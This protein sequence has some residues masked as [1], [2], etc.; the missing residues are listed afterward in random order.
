MVRALFAST[1]VAGTLMFIP[2][3]ISAQQQSQS[4]LTDPRMVVIPTRTQDE[5]SNDIDNAKATQQ[6]AEYRREQAEGRLKQVDETIDGRKKMMGEVDRRK[7]EAKKSKKQSEL[8]ALDIEKKANQQAIDLLNKLK[9]LRRT[10]VDEAN[11]DAELAKVEFSALELETELIRKRME[12]DSLAA[13]GAGDLT[14]STT[15]QVLRELE[16]RVLKL[17]QQQAEATQKVA[18]RQKEIIARRMKLHEAQL[19]LGVPRA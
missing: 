16:I 10:E 1:M 4:I 18:S 17:Q 15:Q 8:I 5:V 13:S 12:Y 7:D 19:K 9:D 3:Q 2:P 11:A 14:L 6:L